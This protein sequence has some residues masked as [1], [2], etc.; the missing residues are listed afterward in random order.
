MSN[1][2]QQ[3]LPKQP[4]TAHTEV[5]PIAALTARDDDH[6]GFAA[7]R[8]VADVDDD[9][10]S[11][12]VQVMPDGEFRAH[13]GRP[14]DVRTGS[15]L[16]DSIAYEAILVQLNLRKNEF[17][18]DYEH[19]TL[20]ADEN[21]QP[22]PAAGWFSPSGIEYVPGEG[23]FALNVKWTSRAAQYLRNDEY[24][25]IS[26]VFAYNK[27]TGR[28][29]KLLHFALTN[30]PAVDG[31]KAVAVLKNNSTPKEETT[32]NEA[33]QLLE[34]LGVTVPEGQSPTAEQY[35]TAMAACKAMKDK[36]DSVET[37][38]QQLSDANEQVASLKAQ[39]T[40]S[41]DLGEYVPRKTYDSLHQEFVALKGEN[42]GLTVDQA[43]EAAKQEGRILAAEVEYFTD[44]GKQKG[45][46][47]LKAQLDARQP[48]A[49][50]T[51]QH[52]QVPGS[53]D[54]NKQEGNDSELSSED[55]AVLKS[56]G[57]DEETFK[58]NK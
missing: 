23:L 31:M 29:T 6:V 8:F 21:G 35:Q 47:A 48:V 33:L 14:H 26:P 22:A 49:A 56:C 46:A 39:G 55:I 41:V 5:N 30:E 3:C 38:G 12:R 58:Q 50:L 45:I 19:Q 20:H 57:F 54:K 17:H 11:E 16:L 37:L 9:G 51:A 1:R 32:M 7:C 24:R 34:L 36:A 44:F 15:W 10:V 2:K 25:Y 52:S 13:D 18:F 40:G 4:G 27:Q 43:I 53:Q 28:P 42:N